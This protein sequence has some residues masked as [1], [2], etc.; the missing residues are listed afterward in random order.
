MAASDQVW[1]LVCG[2]PSRKREGRTF[3]V[4]N[5]RA[6]IDDSG[7]EEQSTAFVLAGF[8]ATVT[9]WAAFT[10]DW[11]RVL[12]KPPALGYFK[13]N[14]AYGLKD[15]FA[16]ER[17]W[18]EAKRDDRVVELA[19]VIRK[20]IPEKFSVAVGH[21][22]YKAFIHDIPSPD[23]RTMADT[24]Y[25][26][27]FYHW[28]T[29]VAVAHS[30]TTRKPHPCDFVFDD[31]GSIGYRVLTWWPNFKHSFKKGFTSMDYSPYF[32]DPPVFKNDT[33]FLPLQA[34]D[35]FAGQVRYVMSRKAL[36]IPPRP[37]LQ[38][39]ERMSGMNVVYTPDKLRD[40]RDDLLKI[41]K[42][43]EAAQP[44][45]LKFKIGGKRR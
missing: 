18:T 23:R 38:I 19:H 7:S 22:D 32:G 25:F 20:H 42:R 16:E 10:D 14:E 4:V 39:I 5:L 43:I 31:Q 44:G 40:L 30:M 9:Q 6:A 1:A 36:Y 28:M 2:L 8:V 26:L 41:A 11:D 21:Q 29:I 45:S 34:A 3:V 13:N 37:P 15:Q 35:L 24:P 17:G 27:L 12:K 33:S